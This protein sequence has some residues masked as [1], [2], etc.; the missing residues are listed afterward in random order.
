[1]DDKKSGYELNE[2]RRGSSLESTMRVVIGANSLAGQLT[3]IGYYTR[4]LI[5]ALLKTDEISD[6]RLLSH[7]RLGP[8]VERSRGDCLNEESK[9]RTASKPSL[10]GKLRPI[11]SKSR[12]LVELYD[13]T[14]SVRAKFALRNYKP[15]DIFHSPDF[16]FAT[17]PGKSVVTIPDLSTLTHSDLHPASRVAYINRHIRRSV[18]HADHIITISD[19]VKREVIEKFGV[20]SDKVTTIY[21]G[22]DQDFSPISR[23]AFEA[24]NNDYSLE[25]KNYFIFVSTIEPRKNIGRLLESYKRYMLVEGAAAFPLVVVGMPGWNSRALHDELE[26]LA[27]TGHVRYLGYVARENLRVLLAGARALLYPSLYEGFG[28][29]VVEAMKSGTAVLTS[30]DSAMSEISDQAALFADPLDTNEIFDNIL[31]LHRDSSLVNR[32]VH[33][34]LE[35]SHRFSWE[36]CA[37]NTVTLYRSL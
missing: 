36:S 30:R 22:A 19:F 9:S 28:L 10:A 33:E 5:Q 4:N 32:L 27:R 23:I 20:S 18:S 17:F 34:G 7:G 11:A 12:I 13:I 37:R 14:T 24:A 35:R 15:N 6:L 8:P 21:P 1:M 29:P 3:G 25:Y 26:R 16:Q 2:R 31:R